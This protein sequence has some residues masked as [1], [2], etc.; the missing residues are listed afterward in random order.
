MLQPDTQTCPACSSPNLWA[1]DHA[2]TTYKHCFECTFSW[3]SQLEENP[4]RLI[5]EAREYA[6]GQDSEDAE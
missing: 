1:D 6:I 3:D 5:V 4:V 2:G